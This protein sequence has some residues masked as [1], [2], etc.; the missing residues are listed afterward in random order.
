M[1]P[2]LSQVDPSLQPYDASLDPHLDLHAA[3]A[4]AQQSWYDAQQQP[5]AEGAEYDHATLLA[6]AAAAA[7]AQ[8]QE[9]HLHQQAYDFSQ[10]PLDPNQPFHQPLAQPGEGGDYYGGE[11][12][13]PYDQQY[14]E[15]H[16]A[17]WMN[18][19]YQEWAQ[20]P[21]DAQQMAEAGLSGLEGYVQQAAAAAQLAARE[22]SAMQQDEQAPSTKGKGKKAAVKK[23][24]K[25]KAKKEPKEKKVRRSTLPLF[26]I[27]ISR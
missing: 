14:A 19:N 25:E 23:E 21:A 16:Q 20:Q 13:F 3:E 7:A 6:N 12:P 8:E 2:S 5:V 22:G 4:A 17:A 11:Q 26:L 10:N 27:V 1:D 18:E 24:P 9:H 15:P